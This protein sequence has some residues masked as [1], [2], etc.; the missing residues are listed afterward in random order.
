MVFA[1]E[2][3]DRI[4]RG[5]ITTTVRIWQRCHVKV[6]GKY[7]MEDGHVIVTSIQPIEVSDITGVLAR[8]CG[9]KGVIDMLKVAQHGP[10]REVFQIEFRY[11]GR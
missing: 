10:G 8:R 2:L 7:L 11:M 6:G 3:R 4:R 5:Q 9:F 1:K